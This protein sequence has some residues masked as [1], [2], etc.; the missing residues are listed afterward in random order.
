MSQVVTLLVAALGLTAFVVVLLVAALVVVR[1][2]IQLFDTK[3]K[4]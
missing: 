4:P 3:G 2:I 1:D